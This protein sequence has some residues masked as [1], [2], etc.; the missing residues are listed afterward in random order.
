VTGSVDRRSKYWNRSDDS[1]VNRGNKSKLTE[2]QT[3]ERLRLHAERYAFSKPTIQDIVDHWFNA[4]QVSIAYNS[5]K[6]WAARHEAQI[7]ETMNDLVDQGKIQLKITDKSLLSTLNI[8]G[9]ETGRVIK[10][11]EDKMMT[12]LRK[13]D[14]DCNPLKSL[15]LTEDSYEALPEDKK[16]KVDKKIAAL[17]KRNRTL[18]KLLP[19]LSS[20]VRDHKKILLETVTTTKDIYD[21]SKLKE[22]KI[23]HEVRKQ[24][25]RKM[26]DAQDVS[27]FNP[28]EA[29]V[30]ESDRLRII[31]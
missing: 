11:M 15:S 8:L 25:G 24:V 21:D 18:I 31:K 14:L 6:E 13:I 12:V 4:Y 26:A 9:V 1:D 2:E 19:E 29:E 20:M 3:K 16:A 5:E 23:Q 17:D 7:I 22:L 10:S 30:V 27:D 28:M